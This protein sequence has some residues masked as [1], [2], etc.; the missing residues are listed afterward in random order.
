MK[1][2]N[3]VKRITLALFVV[4][5]ASLVMAFASHQPLQQTQKKKFIV[6][7]DPGHGGQALG[8]VGRK[9]KEKDIVLDVSKKLKTEL[10]NRLPDVQVLLT[11]TTDINV[12]FKART[13]L[14]NKN[15]ADLFISIHANSANSARKKNPH[16]KGTET[17]VLGF[18][19][20]GEQDVAVRENADMLLEENK[21]DVDDKL[22]G[23]DPND[24]ATFIIFKFLKNQYR[25]QSIKLA[26]LM[27]SEFSKS[28]RINRGVKEQGLAVLATAG[29]PAVLTEIGFI[30]SPEEEDFMLSNAGQTQI[31]E[32]L[33]Q[34]IK[35]YKTAVGK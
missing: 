10:E 13:D 11:R 34:A 9:S 16:V 15:H 23:Y 19:R 17:L 8:A 25:E 35:S 4:G 1:F 14:A 20:V 2:L 27:Q 32:N 28:S 6:V 5:S 18:G 12:A 31:V 3:I 30:S 24:P 26:A 7:L 29:M 22:A 21:S 33:F